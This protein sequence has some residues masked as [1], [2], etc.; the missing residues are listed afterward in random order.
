V[1]ARRFTAGAPLA[2]IGAGFL[3]DVAALVDASKI[4]RPGLNVATP[5][6]GPWDSA[7]V[8]KVRNDTFNV[9]ERGQ[10]LAIGGPVILPGQNES[11]FL[12]QTVLRGVPAIPNLHEARIVVLLEPLAHNAIGRAVIDGV[13]PAY[14]YA[15]DDPLVTGYRARLRIASSGST[16]ATH[17]LERTTDKNGLPIVWLAA[18][19]EV[20]E[21]GR[22]WALISLAQGPIRD[23]ESVIDNDDDGSDCRMS[24]CISTPALSG[25]ALTDVYPDAFT[26]GFGNFSCCNGLA[27]LLTNRELVHVLGTPPN[28]W[29]SRSF[30]CENLARRCGRALWRW[31]AG[32]REIN[33]AVTWTWS[34]NAC[35]QDMCRH[36]WEWVYIT[37]PGF[38]QYVAQEGDCVGGVSS[39]SP[40]TDVLGS[41]MHGTVRYTDCTP[42]IP[43]QWKCSNDFRGTE[44]GDCNFPP[45]MDAGPPTSPGTTVGQTVVKTCTITVP[46]EEMTGWTLVRSC[47]C[48]TASPPSR[49]GDFGGEEITTPCGLEEDGY[50]TIPATARFELHGTR[51]Q[52]NA[53]VWLKVGETIV[54]KWRL[55]NGRIW[56]PFCSSQFDL[57][58]NSCDWPCSEIPDTICVRPAQQ[59][60]T[61]N[62]AAN[63][64]ALTVEGVTDASDDNPCGAHMSK[65]NGTHVLDFVCM[66]T[67]GC[68]PHL[69]LPIFNLEP[70]CVWL[71]PPVATLGS[72]V[73]IGWVML[74]ADYQRND[75]SFG[76]SVA[77]TQGWLCGLGLFKAFFGA[78]LLDE[79][80][81]GP[82]RVKWHEGCVDCYPGPLGQYIARYGLY[83]VTSEKDLVFGLDTGIESED[84]FWR[85]PIALDVVATNFPASIIVRA[86]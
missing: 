8:V 75:A 19:T 28:E 68:F 73:R 49:D 71:A 60:M 66:G 33:C 32:F 36:K 6:N 72:G 86:L 23:P 59:G 2:S 55:R 62:T 67:A 35:P 47:L 27:R 17:E 83:L 9:V 11:E 51:D 22:R 30:A 15:P 44:C 26:L 84:G 4:G 14:I 37:A 10:V 70:C 64:Y 24:D 48:G 78:Y 41:G 43:F 54:L 12:S 42:V 61:C 81:D 57:V 1:T 52:P 80:K 53:E 40:P 20:D 29:S 50:P 69:G 25:P 63:S 5:G 58:A 21:D 45:C 82:D 65:A 77:F 79:T 85:P 3:N 46:D 56:C 7:T 16:A 31:N 38:W 18:D 13:V 39:P 76:G 34:A 74:T